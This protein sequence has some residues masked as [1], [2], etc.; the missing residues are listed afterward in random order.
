M[1]ALYVYLNRDN[2][3]N[4]FYSFHFSVIES[5]EGYAFKP[6]TKRAPCLHTVQEVNTKKNRLLF[7]K[8]IDITEI[9]DI[10]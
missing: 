6:M 10:T 3:L 4:P 1:L 8:T 7:G 9:I 5:T 2:D